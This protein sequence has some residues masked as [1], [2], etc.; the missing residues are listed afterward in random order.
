MLSAVAEKAA[1]KY[2]PAGTKVPDASDTT[3]Q[4]G[5]IFLGL[6]ALAVF[7][8]G[9]VDAQ[10][11]RTWGVEGGCAPS[12]AAAS[13]SRTQPHPPPPPAPPSPSCPSA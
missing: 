1:G 7:I 9:C 6:Y 12:R 13:P 2:L 5:L 10:A 4:G 8:F 3:A 11:P